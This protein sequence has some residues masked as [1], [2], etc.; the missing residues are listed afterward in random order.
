MNNGVARFEAPRQPSAGRTITLLHRA[1]R[2]IV[3]AMFLSDGHRWPPILIWPPQEP[4]ALGSLHLERRAGQQHRSGHHAVQR[5]SDCAHAIGDAD[6]QLND[7]EF[8]LHT[9]LWSR[10]GAPIRTEQISVLALAQPDRND[11]SSCTLK[12]R[13]DEVAGDRSIRNVRYV[14]EAS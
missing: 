8:I 13:D 11:S 6:V 14:R 1:C 7:L 2:D 5:G 12:R 10:H 3:P 4:G 9:S